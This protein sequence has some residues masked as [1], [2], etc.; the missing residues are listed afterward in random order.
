MN[1]RPLRPIRE[2][3]VQ[4]FERDGVTCVRGLLD[5]EW[6]E[7]MQRA[8]DHILDNPSPRGKDITAEGDGGRFAYDDFLWMVNDDYRA[9]VFES[10]TAEIAATFL[11]SPFANILY[12]FFLVKEPHSPTPTN[13]HHDLPGNPVEGKVCGLWVSLDR[14]TL[15][16][17]AVQW[18]RGSHKWGRRFNPI[19]SGRSKT[20]A[21]G[22]GEVPSDL[23]P[24]PDIADH[25]ADYDIVNFDTDPGDIIVSNLLVC[26]G[27]PGNATDRRRRAFGVRYTGDGATY[28]VRTNATFNITPAVDPGLADGDPFPND[29]NHH[30]YPR[31]WPTRPL[32]G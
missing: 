7:R 14:V 8:T 20:Y 29:P 13:W 6:V 11:R 5:V 22:G 16:S 10:P 21:G 30:I 9:F 23:E 4:T 1:R 24:M 17:G 12:N 28:A 32:T 25:M 3:E 27:A 31:V 26:H 2:D 15:D 18:V 19:G